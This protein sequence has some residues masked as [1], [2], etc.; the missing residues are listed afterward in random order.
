MEDI[1]RKPMKDVTVPSNDVIRRPQTVPEPYVAPIRDDEGDRIGKNP[2][3]EKPKQK[4]SEPQKGRGAGKGVLFALLFALVLALAFF[5]A[6][7]FAMATIEVTPITRSAQIDNNFTATVSE[8]DSELIFHFTSLSEVKAKEVPATIEKKIQ[9]KASGTVTIFNAYNGE[10]QRL[11]KNTRL[12]SADHKIFRI[13]QS[14]VVPGAKVVDG[15]TVPGSVDSVVYADV[16]GKEYNIGLGDFTIPGFK[17]DPRYSK[18][19]SASKPDSPIAGGFSGTVKVP[20]DE[21][22]KSAQEELKQDLK[23]IAVEKARAQIPTEVSFFPGSMIVK[24]EEVPEEFTVSD[25]TN[26]SMRATVSVFFFDTAELTKKIAELLP[27]E[28]RENPFSITN[29]SSLDF[30][31]VDDVN[32]VVLSDIENISFHLA[33]KADFVGQIDSKKISADFAGKS[34]KDITEIIK[35]QINIGDA[36]VIVRPMWKKVFPSDPAKINVKIVTK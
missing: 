12:E 34:K 22:I 17:G 18:F 1:I 26:V 21:A 4:V 10:S 29:M 25:T 8:S 30:K 19:Y 27:L 5:V 7:Y 28:D 11:I 33:G 6:N 16:A 14:V 35:K 3:F 13:D 23:K 2:F 20:S 32:N 15:K 36:N 9:K 31:F 24:F